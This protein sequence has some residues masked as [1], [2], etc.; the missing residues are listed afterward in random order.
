MY[1]D[2]AA[3]LDERD[4]AVGALLVAEALIDQCVASAAEAH[5]GDAKP[6]A[7]RWRAVADVHDTY[8]EVWRHLDRARRVLVQRG[9]N[10]AAYDEQRPHARRA[11]TATDEG[12]EPSVDGGALEDAKRALADLKLAVAGA[13]WEAIADRTRGLVAAAPIGRPRQLK[14]VLA[15]IGGG[16]VLALG[17]WA[18]STRPVPKPP[19]FDTMRDELA[20]IQIERKLR[21]EELGATIGA[22]CAPAE[23]H[24]LMKLLVLDGRAPDAKE[25]AAG[26]T[27][28][29]GDDPEVARWARAPKPPRR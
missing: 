6:E 23:I 29:C 8:P 22:H 18:L 25:L 24:E 4:R 28:R 15:G 2:G 27:E 7:E 17:W 21:I 19:K 14:L 1:R 5:A 9:A 11:A 12:K 26:Y 20:E 16:F 10:T 13:D 3:M